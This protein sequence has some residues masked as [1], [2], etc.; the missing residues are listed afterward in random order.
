MSTAMASKRRV[1]V[2]FPNQTIK[3]LD[4][5]KEQLGASSRTEVL[6]TAVELLFWA[7]ARLAKGEEIAAVR[8][9]EISETIAIPGTH[10]SHL[11]NEESSQ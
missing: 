2:V 7:E 10:F 3:K 8:D 11:S 9:D 6:K 5:L 4:Q 1:Q